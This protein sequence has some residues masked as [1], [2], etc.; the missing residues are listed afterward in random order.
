MLKERVIP[1]LLLL[2]GALVKTVKFSDPH[3]VGDPI[4]A[5][6]I[7][8][9]LEVDELIFLDISATKEKRKPD[10]SLI[11][12][13]ASECFMPFCYGGGVRTLEDMRN[14]F[15]L[16]VEKIAVNTAA[17]QDPAF[18]KK[19]A[20]VFGSQAI[21]ASID[22]KRSDKSNYEVYVR[23]GSLN[24]HEDPVSYAK[25]MEVI[26]AGEIFLNSIDKDGTW[27]GFD[28]NLINSVTKAVNIPVIAAG[29]AGSLDD[30]RKVIQ[31]CGVSAVGLG[32]MVVYQK[33]DFG[34]LINFPERNELDKI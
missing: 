10:Y 23:G 24:T 14:L 17:F 31:K 33:K 19:A 20:S 32:S 22:V 29:G 34:V 21:V 2:H 30:I 4:N 11:K 12:Q 6:R 26:G 16:G 13:I 3:Y 7:F 28:L 9:E 1:C 5:V 27:S 15:R 8:N 25:K 18:V